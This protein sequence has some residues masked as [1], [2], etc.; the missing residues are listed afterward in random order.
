DPEIYEDPDTF[1]PA[2]H[3]D[4]AHARHLIWPHAQTDAQVTATDHGCPG[5]D[6]AAYIGTLFAGAM[7]RDYD[8]DLR[9]APEWTDRKFDLNVA[10][11]MGDMTTSY[12]RNRV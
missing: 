1:R 11:P 12:F 10:A 9:D 2:R 8:W 6:V 5:K 7:V 3:A 4:G